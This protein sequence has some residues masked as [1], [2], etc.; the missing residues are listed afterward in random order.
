MSRNIQ[1]VMR[2]GPQV[3]EAGRAEVDADG[4]TF[5]FFALAGRAGA[6]RAAPSEH[7]D[8]RLSEVLGQGAVK[9]PL[10]YRV[11]FLA[12]KANGRDHISL[13]AAFPDGAKSV[14]R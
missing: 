6:L 1:D 4:V 11:R 7:Y 2:F 12:A 8:A 10:P 14:A 9:R 5:S 3:T 13:A